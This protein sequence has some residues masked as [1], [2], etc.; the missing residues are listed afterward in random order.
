MG[1]GE[2]GPTIVNDDTGDAE[3]VND[4]GEGID[5]IVSLGEIARDVQLV[6]C[7]VSFFE[8]PGGEADLVAFGG[9][10]AS[11]GLAN[12]GARAEDEDDGGFNGHDLLLG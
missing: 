6:F 10:G 1:E 9:K 12:V 7:A 11:D 2:V 3:H 8:G 5:Y 4:L